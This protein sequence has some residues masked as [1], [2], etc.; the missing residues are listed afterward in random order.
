MF[1]SPEISKHDNTQLSDYCHLVIRK[2]IE[3]DIIDCGPMRKG[4]V[5][6]YDIIANDLIYTSSSSCFNMEALN[7]IDLNPKNPF[8]HLEDSFYTKARSCAFNFLKE[9]R[10]KNITDFIIIYEFRYLH[11]NNEW[12]R[13]VFKEHIIQTN[14]QDLAHIL[15]REIDYSTQQDTNNVACLKLQNTKTGKVIFLF[16]DQKREKNVISRREKQVL[17]QISKGKRSK[18]IA[19]ILCI[20]VNTVNNHRKNILKKLDVSNMPEALTIQ[21][22][23]N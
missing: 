5:V 3:N 15:Y 9:Q 14:K 16:T 10:I 6:I 12:I 20:S 7:E 4:P 8:I 23:L 11:N 2:T 19:D 21:Q 22:G 13:L 17:H 18:E 1:I